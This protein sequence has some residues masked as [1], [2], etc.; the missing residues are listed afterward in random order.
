MFLKTHT[1]CPEQSSLVYSHADVFILL[2]DHSYTLRCEI[3]S[4]Y[5]VLFVV[6]LSTVHDGRPHCLGDQCN[7]I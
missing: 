6:N 7:M 5:W 4:D 2:V 1:Y 3:R